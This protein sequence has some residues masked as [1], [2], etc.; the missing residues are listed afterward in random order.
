MHNGLLLES[1]SQDLQANPQSMHVLSM[2]E[3]PD[4][5]WEHS[6]KLSLSLYSHLEHPKGQLK[7]SNDL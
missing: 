1:N 5:H 6:T 3:Y 2:K 4:Q 7:S